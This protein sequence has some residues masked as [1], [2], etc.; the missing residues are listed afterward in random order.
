MVIIIFKK[1]REKRKHTHSLNNKTPKIKKKSTKK[2][3]N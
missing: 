2:I 1:K 3:N